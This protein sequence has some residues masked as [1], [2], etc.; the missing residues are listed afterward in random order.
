MIRNADMMFSTDLKNAFFQIPIHLDSS[1]Y[2]FIVLE[3]KVYQFKAFCLGLSTDPGLNRFI[4]C[5]I[6]GSLEG[7]Q[8]HHYLDDLEHCLFLL[9][10]SKDLRIWI[11][12]NQ[13][14]G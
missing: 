3:W 2:L 13:T 8:L 4:T 7:I 11:R 10:L 14:K 12:R 1:P 9:Q 5:V 6:V